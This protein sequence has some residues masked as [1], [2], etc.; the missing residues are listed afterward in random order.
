MSATT[1]PDVSPLTARGTW[2]LPFTVIGVACVVAGGLVAAA[3]AHAPSQNASWAAA[4]LVLVGGVAQ[5]GLGLGQ[6]LLTGRPSARVVTIEFACW[7]AG[8][9]AVI[10]GTLLDQPAVVDVGGALLVVTLV[11]LA[12]RLRARGVRAG[13]GARRWQLYGFQLLVVVLAVSI[14]IGLVLAH[15]RS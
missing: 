13:S 2:Q 7:N 10:I 9:A 15:L 14:P 8:N 11:L 3:T 5:V 1:T 4:Y 12:Y 6:A